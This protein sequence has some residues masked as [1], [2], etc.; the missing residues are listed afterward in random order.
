MLLQLNKMS[1]Y[2]YQHNSCI[3]GESLLWD[4]LLKYRESVACGVK[5]DQVTGGILL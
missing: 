4:H 1:I 5:K 2:Y 3:L